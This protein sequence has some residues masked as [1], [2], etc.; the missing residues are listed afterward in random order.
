M[1]RKGKSKNIFAL[2]FMLMLFLNCSFVKR[3]PQNNETVTTVLK[4]AAFFTNENVYLPEESEKHLAL[5]YNKSMV[6]KETHEV[7]QIRANAT[8]EEEDNEKSNSLLPF[9]IIEIIMIVL[10][11]IMIV[12][13]HR[14]LRKMRMVH[15]SILPLHLFFFAG[16]ATDLII[17]IVLG[18]IILIEVI[19]LVILN[20]I[21]RIYSAKQVVDEVKRGKEEWLKKNKP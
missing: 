6:F 9:I 2:L 18:V 8:S 7:K 20:F 12:K 15:H 3:V 17:V 16:I 10:L 1:N 14:Q 19:Y 13:F 5:N 11:T 4:R 21:S